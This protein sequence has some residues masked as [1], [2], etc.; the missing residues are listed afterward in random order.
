MPQ[1]LT[2]NAAVE[3]LARVHDLLD[4]SSIRFKLANP[5]EGTPPSFEQL[6]LMEM[7]YRRFVALR[8]AHPDSEIVP[9]KLVDEM[10]HRHI[11]DTRAYAEDCDRIFGEFVHH[12]PYFGMRGP[13][14]EQAL[15]DAY[16]YT[17]ERYREAFGEPPPDTWISP[18]ARR[19]CRTQC[20]PMKC[21]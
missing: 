15:H 1:T 2:T 11:L 3:A 6:D 18:D 9:C 4:L 7:E 8:L 17:L 10:W 20:R 13:D 16:D 14:D 5:E 19:R 21:R 12:F